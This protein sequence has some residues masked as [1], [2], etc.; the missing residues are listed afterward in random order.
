M[1]PAVT[2]LSNSRLKGDM[3]ELEN[4][5]NLRFLNLNSN[6]FS[7]S[8]PS[9]KG[10]VQVEIIDLGNN[11]LHG[12]LPDWIGEMISLRVWVLRLNSFHGPTPHQLTSL[13]SLQVLGLSCNKFSGSLPPAI[14]NFTAMMKGRTTRRISLNNKAGFYVHRGKVLSLMKCFDICNNQPDGKIPED[15]GYSNGLDTITCR[16]TIS[17]AK[18]LL[19]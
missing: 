13:Q 10:T 15:N 16:T 14:T 11:N 5:T 1:T 17:A 4:Q 2:D 6:Q 9:L 3:P 12:H 7:G 18:F 8:I 19:Q